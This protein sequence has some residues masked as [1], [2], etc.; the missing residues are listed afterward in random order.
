[1]ALVLRLPTQ[2]REI[3]VATYFSGRTVREAAWVLGLAPAVAKAR[4]YQAMH[5]L[6]L[7]AAACPPVDGEAGASMEAAK[8]ST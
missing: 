5:D 3:I 1:M 8:K 2:Q 4:L 6:S 7:V